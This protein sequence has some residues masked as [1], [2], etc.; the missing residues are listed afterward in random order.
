MRYCSDVHALQAVAVSRSE[1]VKC[2]QR[3]YVHSSAMTVAQ[4]RLLTVAT[5]SAWQ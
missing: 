5:T 3:S 4:Q 1:L 2:C